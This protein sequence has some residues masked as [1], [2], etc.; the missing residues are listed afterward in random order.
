MIVDEVIIYCKAG[1]GGEG[2]ACSLMLSP[3]RLIG[4]GGKGGS[5]GNVIIRVSPHHSDLVWF[6]GRKEFIAADGERGAYNNRKGRT[7]TEFI[8]NVPR[9]TLVRDLE[10][11]LITDLKN[12][13]DELVICRGGHGGEGNFKKFY[14]LP[15]APGEEKQAIL[16]FR[17]PAQAAITG[18]A[19][20]GK[21]SIFNYLTGKNFKVAEYPFTTQS[22]VW[23]DAEFNYRLFTLMDAQPIKHSQGESH[24]HNYFLR[25]LYRPKLLVLVSDNPKT[26]KAEFKALEGE[27]ALRDKT[28]LEGKKI[29]YVLN[30]CDQIKKLPKA[31]GFVCVSAK[32]GAGMEAL[33]ETIY[34]AS[35]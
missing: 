8:V 18:F 2:S 34:T 30:K 9:G 1:N 10:Y 23:A 19:N 21:T 17:I 31:K 20:S 7:G 4:G 13:N 27:I 22:P 6:R 16:D 26:F 15:P 5:G 28:L 14:T 25:H 33:R 12:P 11:N 32:T 3:R 35:K 29:L 24:D